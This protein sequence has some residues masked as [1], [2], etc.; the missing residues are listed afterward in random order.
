MIP[1]KKYTMK[2]TQI[3]EAG[4]LSLCLLF[5]ATFV[6]CD[7]KSDDPPK[8]YGVL[9]TQSQLDWQKMEY[10]MFIHFG[11]NTFTDVEW[12]NGKEDPK[13]FNPSNV[14]CRQ[15]AA[16]AKAA[17]MKGIILTAKHHDG[18][19][20]WPSEYS[21]HT[22]RESKWKDGKGDLLRELSEA[23]KENG[24]KFGVYLSPWDQNHPDYGTPGYNQIFVNTLSEVL[25]NYGE[26]FE[27]WFD[28]ANGEGHGGKKQEYDWKLFHET[29]YKNQPNAMIFSDIGPGCRWVGNEEG[30]AGETNWSR[31]NVDGF[32]PG[33]GAPPTDTLNMG[34]VR[35]EA[36]IPAET[37]V[38]IRPGWFYSPSTDD[39]VK[40]VD[41]LMNIYYSSVGRNSNLLLNV[42]PART[43]RIHANDSTRLMEFRRAMDEAFANDLT[44]GASISAT[45][46]RGKSDKFSASNLLNDDYDSYWATN[47]D[48]TTASIEIDLGSE[49]ALNRL[50]I[51]EYIPLGQR[52]ERFS[53]EAWVDGK[54]APVAKATTIGYKRILRFPTVTTSKLKIN[55]E[56]SLACPVL[57]KI[58]LHLAP[59][60]LS[61]PNTTRNKEGKVTIQCDTPDPEIRYTTDGSQPTVV[62]PIYTG[63][64]DLPDGGVVK[65]IALINK[66]KEVS[67]VVETEFD[68]APVQ[69]TVVSPKGGSA[70][71][72]IDATASTAE[73]VKGTP[74]VID[75]GKLLI[76][77]GFT[78]TPVNS[79]TANNVYKYNLY[80]SENGTDWTKIKSNASFTN[81]KNNPIKQ[82]VTFDKPTNAKFI[83]LEPLETTAT[84]A[85]Y[86]VAEIGVIT[87]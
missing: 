15:W 63:T 73:I 52:V 30:I 12:G 28:G 61:A 55:I 84:G 35:G 76:L 65:A 43:G 8:P 20:L 18:F 87:R 10:Y 60:K 23:C 16:T 71:H 2:K 80:V 82:N 19:C 4:I 58:A 5:S 40:S 85:N 50:S 1:N 3:L 57:N 38:S 47:D 69:W 41:H 22:V 56:S 33:A 66:G 70:N 45:Q 44:K 11:P 42:P 51:Q 49:K 53:V 32:T 46:V 21:K 64:F 75:F 54:W 29:V 78:F 86:S 74:L 59:E 37:D 83:K 31:L 72:A 24:L 62:S 36:W 79:V 39:K 17:G 7:S 13:V 68:L 14:D 6:S 81:I 26:I 9:P 34:N 77:K 25:G 27:Q 67:D 48:Q